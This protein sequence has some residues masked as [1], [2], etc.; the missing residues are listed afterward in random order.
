MKNFNYQHE[1]SCMKRSNFEINKVD[2]VEIKKMNCKNYLF[3]F[4]QKYRKYETKRNEHFQ[5]HR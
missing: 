5:T 1:L 2:V 4:I 3:I